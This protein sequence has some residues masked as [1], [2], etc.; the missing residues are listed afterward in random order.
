ML[1]LAHPLQ[2]HRLP[3]NGAGGK[4]CIGGNIVGAVVPITA[5][6]FDVDAAHAFEREAEQLGEGLAQ[7][8]N[9]LAVCPYGHAVV[10]PKRHGTGGSD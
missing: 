10:F 8:V 6:A 2:T 9:A 7:R 3:G 1:L 5:G 4:R